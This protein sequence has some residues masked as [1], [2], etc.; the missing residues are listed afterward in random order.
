MGRLWVSSVLVLYFPI[1]THDWIYRVLLRIYGARVQ[2]FVRVSNQT[3]HFCCSRLREWKSI[4]SLVGSE[5]ANFSRRQTENWEINSKL[6]RLWQRKFVAM[7]LSSFDSNRRQ[8]ATLC[9]RE[10]R[11]WAS[12]GKIEMIYLEKTIFRVTNRSIGGLRLHAH[13]KLCIRLSCRAMATM[14]FF[15]CA[16][17]T[18]ISRGRWSECTI[19]H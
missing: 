2:Q 10:W 3:L 17:S 14:S 4:S 18:L 8:D 19:A 9:A 13:S 15:W 12:S 7:Q 16:C 11:C 5:S 1:F 6:F